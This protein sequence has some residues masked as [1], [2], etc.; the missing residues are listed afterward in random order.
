M[1]ML[2]VAMSQ[3]GPG[4]TQ[5]PRNICPSS[6]AHKKPKVHNANAA[7]VL[8][9]FQPLVRSMLLRHCCLV[10]HRSGSRGR[11]FG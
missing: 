8:S 10:A 5:V 4:Y 2:L 9:T 3:L 1:C 11:I 6:L 7:G